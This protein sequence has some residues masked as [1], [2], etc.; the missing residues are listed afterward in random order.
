MIDKKI[1]ITCINGESFSLKLPK[2]A[3]ISS[4]YAFSMPKAGSTLL[5][6]MLSGICHKLSIPVINPYSVA[7]ASGINPTAIDPSLAKCLRPVGYAYL[8]FRQ[9]FP[10]NLNADLSTPKKILL[11]RDP[12]DMLTSL[13]FSLRDSHSIPKN[14]STMKTNMV[15]QRKLVSQQNIND[16]AIERAPHYL[17][18]FKDYR[19]RLLSLPHTRIYRY[20]DIIFDK[21]SWLLAMLD[22]FGVLD[23]YPEKTVLQEAKKV[24]AKHDLRPREENPNKHVRQVTPGN[25]KKHLSSDTIK[26]LNTSLAPFLD[27]FHYS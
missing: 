6:N 13:Y 5:D 4:F 14:A 16:F 1:E 19:K 12:R 10:K 8:G 18:F 15:N 2:P 24:A 3:T 25:Y 11:V 9:V 23:S 27:Y 22:F 20:E 26:S 21:E 7:W 17:K